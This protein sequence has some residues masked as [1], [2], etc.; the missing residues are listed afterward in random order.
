MEPA[1]RPNYIADIPSQKAAIE[2]PKKG[3]LRP[4]EVRHE[5]IFGLICLQSAVRAPGCRTRPRG[6]GAAMAA[7][8]QLDTRSLS[9]RVALHAR[10]RPEMAREVRARRQSVNSGGAVEPSCPADHRKSHPL[11][12]IAAKRFRP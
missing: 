11:P 1:P 5:C 8:Q 7:A 2:P 10:P 9:A 3:V 4:K 12:A 6:D